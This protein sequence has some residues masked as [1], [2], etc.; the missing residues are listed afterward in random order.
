MKKLLVLLLFFTG[1]F[2]IGQQL[3]YQPINPAFGGETFNYQWLLSS[4]NAQNSFTDPNASEGNDESSLEAF[5]ENLNRQ[6][7]KKYQRSD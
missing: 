7:L 5:G 4:A 3:S 2:C 6:I 1:Y